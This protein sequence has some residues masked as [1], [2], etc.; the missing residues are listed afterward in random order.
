MKHKFSFIILLLL[1]VFNVKSFGITE[2]VPPDTSYTVY[3]SYIKELKRFPFIKTVDTTVTQDIKCFE[4]I[5][6]KKIAFTSYGD[7]DLKLSVYRPDNELVYP[8]VLMIHGGGWNSGS[9][10]MQK[11]LAINLAKQGFATFTIEYRLIPEA[12]FPAAEEDLNDAVEW[13]YN[14]GDRFK[15]NRNSIAVSGCSAGG[16]LAALIGTKNS[17]N[18]IK[19]II[20]IDGI[21]TFIDNETIERAQKARDTGAKMP[22]DAQWLNGTYSENPKH[23][24]EASALSWINDNSAP[25]CFINSSIDRFHNGRD[26]HIGV[27]KDIGIYS[28][29]HTFEDTPHTFW[30]FHPWHISTVNYAANFLRKIFDEPADFVNKE[31]DFVVA[32]DGSGDFTS[33]Q[34]AINAIPDFRKQPS[35]IFI[36]NGYYRE[37]VII[38]ETKHSLTLIGENKYKTILSFNNFASKVSRLGDE[39]GT[40]GSASIY[41]CPDNFIAENI[42]FENA[43]GPIGQAVA[44]IVRSNNSSFFNCRFLGFQDTLYTHKAGSKQYYKNCYIEGTVDFIFGSSIAY[45]DE[46]EIF[47]KQN[48][49]ITAA[50][51]PEEQAYGYIFKHCKIEGDNKDSFYLGRPWRAYAHVVFLECE[52]SNVIRKEGWNNWG[53]VLNE[54]TSFYGEYANKGEGAEISR[55]VAWV[56]QLDDESIKK[57]S[58]I[59]VLGEEF[60]ANHIQHSIK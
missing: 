28:E 9:P 5:A 54:L 36:R 19:A 3:S 29:A 2:S 55:R 35:T 30:L 49:Y 21:S 47:C 27:L 43:A 53:N 42:T 33:V 39:I 7:R 23:W 59:N 4:K 31:Y 32:K 17:N 14:N 8:A 46:C 58:I 26:A 20:N 13:V 44:I 56:N 16:Q 37:K 51:T 1:F 52:M 41:V 11:A 18:R 34:D 25:I 24:I 12:L 45:F 48:G 6:Y 15:I 50:S 60:V 38:P 10:D 40:S 22:V 57:Y